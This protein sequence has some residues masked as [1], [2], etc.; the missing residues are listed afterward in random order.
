M[1]MEDPIDGAVGIAL[2]VREGLVLQVVRRPGECRALHG[3][4]SEDQDDGTHD[5]M[6]PKAAMGEHAV[7]AGRDAQGDGQVHPDQ[8]GEI[9]PRDRPLPHLHDR[10]GRCDEWG[11]HHH[12]NGCSVGDFGDA[13]PVEWESALGSIDRTLHGDLKEPGLCVPPRRLRRKPH[14]TQGVSTSV[15]RRA[16]AGAL[17]G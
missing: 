12:E 16:R 8:Q 11:D 6:G 13:W 14:S 9:A 7:E 5:R 2:L 4:R 1:G 3:H 17:K 15:G 10:D